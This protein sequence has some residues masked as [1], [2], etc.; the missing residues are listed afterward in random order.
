MGEDPRV[1][2]GRGQA[3]PGPRRV[4]VGQISADAPAQWTVTL[5]Y[6]DDAYQVLMAFDGRVIGNHMTA[7]PAATGKIL[8]VLADELD[9][10]PPPAPEPEPEPEYV[11]GFL[12]RLFGRR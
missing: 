2:E 4:M 1:I 3:A 6:S 5:P 10:P 12:G 7:S 11:P 9:P 8:R